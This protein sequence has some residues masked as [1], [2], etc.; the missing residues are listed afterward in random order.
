[1]ILF[2]LAYLGGVLTIVSP[3]ILPVLP[4]VFARADRRFVRS[5]VPML[6]G[7]AV[8]FA[9]VATLAAVAGGWAVKANQ[10]GRA[11]AIMLLAM[12]GLTLIFPRLADHLAKPFVTLGAR[13]SQSVEHADAM[14][15]SGLLPSILLGVATGLLWLPCAGPVL[16]LI[17]SG[18]A[19]RGASIGTSLLLLAYAAGAATS[20]ALALLVGGRVLAVMKRSLGVGEWVRRGLGAAVLVAVATIALGLDAGF[21]PRVS[22]A[23][24]AWLEQGLL[25]RLGS[26]SSTTE[27][28]TQPSVVMS[29]DSTMMMKAKATAKVEDLPI[30]GALPALS[31]AVEWLNSPP[32]TTDGPVIGVHTPE[33]AFEKDL[34]NVRTA[35]SELKIGYPVAIDSNYAIWRAFSNHYW[36]AHY[37]IDGQGH[38]RHHHFG[39]GDYDESERVIQQLLAEAGNANVSAD[40]VSVNALGAEAA[41]DMGNVRSPETYVGYDRAKHFVSPGGAVKDNRHNYTV[42][43]PRLNEWGLSGDWTIGKEY[44]VLNKEGRSIVYRFHAR[45]LHLVLGPAPDDR[46]VRFRVTID[47]AP[48]GASHGAD[49]DADGQGVVTRQRLYQ[50]VRQSGAIG[51]RK[52]EIQFLDPGVQAYAFTFG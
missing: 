34:N 42:T 27:A 19:L 24:T 35:V 23:S 51:D 45:D 52:F 43:S 20:L 41:P 10:Y 36:P 12:F 3:C 25:D 21:L 28:Q 33:F 14:Q 18:A 29:G 44:A 2:V 26:T 40:V 47:G 38:I 46:P 32:L 17:L 22:I 8:T 39:E 31:G 48:P 16:G 37:F 30:E 1:M 15:R 6:V 4:F 7:M 5:G 49:A 9:V 13:L 50:L 11:A